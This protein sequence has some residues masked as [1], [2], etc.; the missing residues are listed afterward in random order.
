MGT[1]PPSGA[2]GSYVTRREQFDWEHEHEAGVHR[3][4]AS[5]RDVRDVQDKVQSVE[6]RELAAAQRLAELTDAIRR[7]D[8]RVAVIEKGRDAK[9]DE[10]LTLL[11]LSRR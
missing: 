8:E 1:S 4:A 2:D 11:K 5:T 3:G 7:L 6:A 9:L 10:I